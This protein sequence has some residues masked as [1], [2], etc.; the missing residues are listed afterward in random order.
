MHPG[1]PFYKNKDD[2]FW[3]IP[4][5]EFLDEDPLITAK[6]EFEEETSIQING[7]FI[8]LTAVRLKS[9]KTVYAWAIQFDFDERIVH[10]NIFQLEWPPRSGKMQEFPEVDKGQWF[11]YSKARQKIAAAQVLLLDEAIS[12][13]KASLL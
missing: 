9:G 5:G 7:D 11:H 6:R 4:K 12:Y 1:G 2:G 8:P 10:S 13:I 3:S